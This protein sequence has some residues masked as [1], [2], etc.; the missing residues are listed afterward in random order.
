VN[1]SKVRLSI[2]ADP[3]PDGK[4]DNRPFVVIHDGREVP[5]QGIIA[6]RRGEPERGW[7]PLE[8]GE[9]GAWSAI[10]LPTY[11]DLSKPGRY[12]VVQSHVIP[13]QVML[14]DGISLADAGCEPASIE[15]RADAP[16]PPPQS[17]P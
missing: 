9:R 12:W 13:M 11:F 16:P 3:F 6:D 7:I 5:Y 1:A 17:S 4:L 2:P 10:D 8:P 14:E 15:V